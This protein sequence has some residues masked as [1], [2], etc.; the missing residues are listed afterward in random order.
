VTPDNRSHAARNRS[1]LSYKIRYAFRHPGRVWPYARRRVR[2]LK[3]GMRTGD[4]VE[5]YRAVMR[6][7][8]ARGARA[9][10]GSKTNE[11]WLRNGQKQFDYLVGHGLDPGMR[12]L[13]IGCGN[14]RAGRLFIEYLDASNYYGIDISPDILLA[15][16]DTVTEFGLQDKLPRVALVDDLKLGFL[17]DQAFDVVYAHSVFSHSP[18]EVI[19]ECLQHIGRVLVPGGFFDFT[20][21]RTEG[22]EHQVLR[23]DFYYRT[24]TLIGLAA[25]YGLEARIMEDWEPLQPQSKLRVTHAAPAPARS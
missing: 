7:D 20:F 9:A 3:L 5:Y 6:S 22:V 18:I 14:L 8:A 25:R 4:H 16:L 12:M 17:P 2:D 24:E 1:R 21:D 15:A 10:V 13:E 11:A 23:E 19:A